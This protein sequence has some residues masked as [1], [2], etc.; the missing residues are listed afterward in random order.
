MKKK[1]SKW[2]YYKEAFWEKLN[3]TGIAIVA[4]GVFL[5]G[6]AAFP[7]LFIGAGLEILYLG[8]VPST[9]KYQKIVN[10]REEKEETEKLEVEKKKMLSSLS[11]EQQLRFKRLERTK[12]KLLSSSKEIGEEKFELIY[13]DLRKL[14]YLL[15]SFL[16]LSVICQKYRRHLKFSN[17][18]DVIRNIKELK[19]KLEK[20]ED[21]KR[22][23]NAQKMIQRNIRILNKRLEKLDK[24]T[25]NL[26]TLEAQVETIEDTFELVHDE[27]ITFRTPEEITEDLDV[28]VSN[29]ELTEEAL[30]ESDSI[31]EEFRKLEEKEAAKKLK[32]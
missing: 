22:S 3:L 10:R 12:D 6:E 28:L 14:D 29:V 1:L 27:V 13:E 25:G 19:E 16:N 8:I 5:G 24:I 7:I 2:R 9:K 32:E 30:R 20:D 26:R 18:K 11:T 15:Y 23:K 21:V 4:L 17:R 31:L